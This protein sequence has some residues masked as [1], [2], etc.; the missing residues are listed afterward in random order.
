[1]TNMSQL[2]AA[3]VD[4]V[5]PRVCALCGELDVVVCESCDMRIREPGGV[6]RTLELPEGPVVVHSALAAGPE[7]LRLITLFKDTG[8]SDLATYLG[9]LLREAGRQIRTGIVVSV[10]QSRRAYRRRGWD[11][12]QTLARAA[13]FSLER[14]LDVQARHIDQTTLNRDARWRNVSHTVRVSPERAQII[15][16]RT[17]TIIDDV[18]TTGA[19]MAEVARALTV[20]GASKV[21][22][23]TLASVVRLSR[24]THR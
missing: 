4:L 17:V 8:R 15:R 22:G 18:V 14:V 23:V 3:L 2:L 7:I 5:V 16:G 21:Q 9:G 20:A 6:E 12:A 13:G 19:T 10:P 11:P 24:Q 1:M